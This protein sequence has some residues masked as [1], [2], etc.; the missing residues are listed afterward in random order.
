MNT[1]TGTPSISATE[2]RYNEFMFKI[3]AEMKPKSTVIA[4]RI[5]KL[6]ADREKA[7]KKRRTAREK[8]QNVLRQYRETEED[9]TDLEIRIR[10]EQSKHQTALMKE[11]QQEEYSWHAGDEI[12]TSP[13]AG[14]CR[15]LPKI[16]ARVQLLGKVE[17]S[18]SESQRSGA[19]PRP[20]Q[21]SSADRGD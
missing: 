16:Q 20:L 11:A 1:D 9:L 2:S 8:V 17:R 18:H 7:L 10:S 21:S 3:Q 12:Q 14:L 5:K 15:Y 13:C 4:D 6:K 19:R